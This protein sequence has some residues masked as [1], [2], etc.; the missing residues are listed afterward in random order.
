M[1]LPRALLRA[2]SVLQVEVT[3]HATLCCAF[4]SFLVFCQGGEEVPSFQCRSCG[5]GF[6]LNW[7]ATSLEAIFGV[8]DQPLDMG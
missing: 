7:V 6:N 8:N 3:S 1:F 5:Y 4:F 2:F